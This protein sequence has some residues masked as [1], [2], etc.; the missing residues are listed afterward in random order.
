M[1]INEALRTVI[2]DVYIAGAP[3][4][5]LKRACAAGW[6]MTCILLIVNNSVHVQVLLTG[7]AGAESLADPSCI[8]LWYAFAWPLA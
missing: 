7:I 4:G 3:T 5:F 2:L 8:Q 1:Y 6:R